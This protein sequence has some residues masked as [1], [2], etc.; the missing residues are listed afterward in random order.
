MVGGERQRDP[1]RCPSRAFRHPSCRS[2]HRCHPHLHRSSG[3]RTSDHR[4]RSL[5]DFSLEQSSSHHRAARPEPSPAGDRSSQWRQRIVSS[6]RHQHGRD[7]R[8]ERGDRYHRD[9]RATD[10]TDPHAGGRL[11]RQCIGHRLLPRGIV[12][13]SRQEVH[14]ETAGRPVWRRHLGR[15]GSVIRH[16]GRTLCHPGLDQWSDLFAHDDHLVI[17]GGERSIEFG[18]GPAS[19]TT[20]GTNRCPCDPGQWVD[21]CALVGAGE[22][23]WISDHPVLGDCT[24]SSEILSCGAGSLLDAS[25]SHELRD[26]RC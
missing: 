18:P 16:A 12:G 17:T 26:R 20:A 9:L 24:E 5:S 15:Q 4:L 2:Q 11:Q 14:G 6:C 21:L 25:S 1:H 7:L 10:A 13:L 22:Q 23:L 19:R 8:M 3:Q